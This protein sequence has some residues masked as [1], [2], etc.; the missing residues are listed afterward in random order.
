MD[1]GSAG[2]EDTHIISTDAAAE[3]IAVP[4]QQA[5]PAAPLEGAPTEVVAPAEATVA[6]SATE[7]APPAAGPLDSENGAAVPQSA[8]VKRNLMALLGVILAIPVWPAGLVL[9][10][11]GLLNASAR[12]T[13]K[14][15]SIVGLVLSV[16]TGAAVIAELA[17]ATSTVSD[18][19]ALDAGCKN[20]EAKLP[21]DLATLKAD[22]TTLTSNIDSATSSDNS[23]ETVSGDL[24]AIQ[25]DLTDAAGKATHPDVKSDLNTMNTQLQAIAAMLSDI[26]KH[27]ASSEGAAA[28][29]LTTLTGTDSHIDSLCSSY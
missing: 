12:K 23:I 17:Q 24:A 27:S 28:A 9:S 21:A 1:S 6:V 3:T 22:T 29:A 26:Q 15:L 25:T 2:S 16:L 7:V 4:S 14:I 8:P 18:S 20:V 10:T 5:A 11:L 19:T 13:G